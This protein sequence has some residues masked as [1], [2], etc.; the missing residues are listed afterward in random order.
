MMDLENNG[1][2]QKS[3]SD[4]NTESIREHAQLQ[5]TKEVEAFIEMPMADK[6]PRLAAV[7]FAVAVEYGLPCLAETASKVGEP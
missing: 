3:R 5:L 7:A 4:N 1:E 2:N 6:S